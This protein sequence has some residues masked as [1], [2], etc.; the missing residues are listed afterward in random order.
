MTTLI[1]LVGEQPMPVLLPALYLRPAETV[2]LHTS[3][4]QP[5]ATRLAGLLSGATIKEGHPYELRKIIADIQALVAGRSNIIFNL[6]GG[7]KMMMLAAYTIAAQGNYEFIYLESEGQQTMLYRY[8]MDKGLPVFVRK[9]VL[10]PVINL[11]DYLRAHL[12]TYSIEGFS[13]D[14]NG[15]LTFGGRFER[16][17]H[18]VL[19]QSCDEV[20]A[21]VR[22]VDRQIDIDLVL[23]CG[24]QVGIAEVKIAGSEERPKQGIDQLSTAGGREYL[25]IYTTKF[26]ITGRAMPKTIR[27]LAC[28]KNVHLIEL[29]RYNGSESLSP[30]HALHLSRSI[31]QRLQK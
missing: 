28:E 27:K 4:T 23:R 18:N 8:Q 30:Q 16:A 5:V 11:D 22:Y 20:M 7:T 6:T 10:P 1:A 26:L 2:L 3:R 14:E 12:A 17:V 13:R 21:G 15:N 31:L 9:D 25:G 29:G 24:N 19:L